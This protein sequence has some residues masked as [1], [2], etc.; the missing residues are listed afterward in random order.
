MPKPE[1]HVFVCTQKRPPGHPR[2]SCG[3]RECAAVM[4]EFLWQ[5][6]HKA[7]YETIR[8]TATACMGPCGEGPTVLVYPEGVMYRGVSKDAVNRIVDEHLIEDRPVKSM[9]MPAEFWG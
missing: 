3:E 7:L 4:E 1:K 8:V 5:V 6:Q 2:G 9:L